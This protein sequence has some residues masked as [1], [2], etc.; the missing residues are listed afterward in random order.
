MFLPPRNSSV[1]PLHPA[2]VLPIIMQSSRGLHLHGATPS[3]PDRSAVVPNSFHPSESVPPSPPYYINDQRLTESIMS[4]P[5]VD[6]HRYARASAPTPLRKLMMLHPPPI[7][8]PAYQDSVSWPYHQ[9]NTTVIDSGP[10]S[11][12]PASVL[13]MGGMVSASHEGST[14]VSPI[15]PVRSMQSQNHYFGASTTQA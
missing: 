11:E 13:H 6:H 3:P 4:Y 10:S 15:P 2:S 14:F 8:A 5:Q 7:S 9:W 1:V 12:N